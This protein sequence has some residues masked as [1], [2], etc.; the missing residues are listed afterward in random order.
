MQAPGARVAVSFCQVYFISVCECTCMP[1]P[2]VC[3]S[4]NVC[5]CVV[6][7][8]VCIF[9]SQRQT[10]AIVPWVPSTLLFKTECRIV[11]ELTD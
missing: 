3:A 2:L 5:I 8:G 6:S 9:G 10:L 7:I 4:T 11:L 1:Y